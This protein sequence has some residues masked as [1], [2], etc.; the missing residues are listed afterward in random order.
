MPNSFLEFR[1]S[2]LQIYAIAFFSSTFYSEIRPSI[3]NCIR[4]C[5]ACKGIK[6]FTIF[7]VLFCFLSNKVLKIKQNRN[8]QLHMEKLYRHSWCSL[9]IELKA[10]WCRLVFTLF[11]LCL[12]LQNQTLTT[13]FSR[14]S[15]SAILM[16]SWEEGLLCSPKCLSRASLAAI[17]DKETKYHF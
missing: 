7:F 6:C 3:P 13:S 10:F 1:P 12:L 4:S 8:P 5:L 11:S 17:L 15:P 14:L 2:T 9:I 16:I